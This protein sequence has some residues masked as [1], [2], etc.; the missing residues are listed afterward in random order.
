ML[1]T[2]L[3]QKSGVCSIFGK[4]KCEDAIQLLWC[5]SLDGEKGM[6]W[7][8][9]EKSR[10]RE[11]QQ[12]AVPCQAHTKEYCQTF[13][14]IDKGNRKEATY[15]MVIPYL[16]AKVGIP[17][18][19]HGVEQHICCQK[20]I[21]EQGRQERAANGESSKELPHDLCQQVE[22]IWNREASHLADLREMDQVDGHM[23]EKNLEGQ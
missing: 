4:S 7:R 8:G 17:N 16:G 18:V 3:H 20:R 15:N 19:Q 13:H 22:P 21:G 14:L 9:T 6:M 2:A 5:N 11:M 1:L 12:T 23:T 10:S